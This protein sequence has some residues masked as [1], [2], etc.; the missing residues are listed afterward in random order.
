MKRRFGVPTRITRI[1]G[2]R[3]QKKMMIIILIIIKVDAQIK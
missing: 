3:N 2:V 1:K